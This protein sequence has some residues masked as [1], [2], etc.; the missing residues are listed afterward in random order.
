MFSGEKKGRNENGNAEWGRI[1]GRNTGGEISGK[2]GTKEENGDW[3]T[4]ERQPINIVMERKGK[5]A[6]K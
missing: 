2:R 6:G 3:K 5:E 1:K 4:K